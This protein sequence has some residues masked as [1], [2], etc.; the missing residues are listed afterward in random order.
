M[1]GRKNDLEGILNGIDYRLWDPATDPCL[2]KNFHARDLAGKAAC[3]R[4]LQARFKL[5]KRDAPLFGLVSRLFWQKGIDLILD[6]LPELA[7]RNLQIVV[8]GAG[9]PE[10]E[11]R[12]HK[13]TQIYPGTIALERAFDVGLAHQ[14]QAGSDFFLMPSR[15]EPCGLSQMHGMA[16]GAIPIV[17]HTGGLADTVRGINP[18]NTK[19]GVAT[20]ISFIPSTPQ[21]IVR[22]VDKALALY[23]NPKH[24]AQIRQNAMAQRFSWER[25][26]D[27][28]E[29]LY[30]AA[31]AAAQNAT[32]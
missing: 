21:S 15:Y 9:D 7:K 8:Q 28:Y 24:L 18:V 5:P 23:K 10:L 26:S 14:V 30:T 4:A 25:A 13:A 12:L 31:Q 29:A 17:R 1:R 3:K 11:A 16:Y 6:A 27:A 20:G 22:C 32:R 19:K 2:A